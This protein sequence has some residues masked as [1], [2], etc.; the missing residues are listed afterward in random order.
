MAEKVTYEE[1][2]AL[3]KENA[4]LIKENATEA[5][6]NA[7]E[8]KERSK[9]IDAERART[10]AEAK[11]RSKAID[12]ERARIEAEMDKR[13][14]KLTAKL[15]KLSEL[16]G[17]ISHNNGAF[18]EEYFAS[19]L[20]ETKT[21][22]NMKFDNFERN[23]HAKVGDVQDEFDNVLYNGT[24]VAIIEVKYKIHDTYLDQMVSKKV[25][26]F[27]KLFPYYKDYDIYLGIGSMAF[28]DD[29]ITKAKKLGI[30]IL[31]QKGNAI[32]MDTGYAKAY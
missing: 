1:V 15:D 3:I 6:K 4:A 8:A 23:V 17:G 13:D 10:D 9:A 5:K 12:A 2:L 16:I 32:E 31:R 19:K 14:A 30:G 29:V 21:F 20:E 7:A 22:A 26:N 25:S 28:Y 27:R 11:E 18:A 24:S